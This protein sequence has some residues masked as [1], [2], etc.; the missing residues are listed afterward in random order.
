MRKEKKLI[1]IASQIEELERK[2]TLGKD[3]QS[4]ESKILK[5]MDSLSQEEMLFIDDYIMEKK[6]KNI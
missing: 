5:I 6:M 2:I 3:V 1:K 4:T